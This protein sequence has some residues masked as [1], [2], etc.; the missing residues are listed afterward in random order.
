[1]SQRLSLSLGLRWEVNPAPGVT[2]GLKPYTSRVQSEYMDAGA[3]G[4]PL[5]Q[6][7]WFNFAPRLGAAYILH[8]ARL[9]KRLCVAEVAFSSIPAS[10]RGQQAFA[11]PGFVAE[12]SFPLGSFPAGA[13][14]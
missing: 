11:G 2:K 9:G 14:G 12:D 3:A 13:A 10:S 1:M 8:N 7:T 5:W 4:T 6:T